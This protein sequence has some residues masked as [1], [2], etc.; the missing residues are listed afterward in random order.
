MC[1]SVKSNPVVKTLEDAFLQLL[2]SYF[3]C[4]LQVMQ[5]PAATAPL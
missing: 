3:T 4:L 2:K 1:V 5:T